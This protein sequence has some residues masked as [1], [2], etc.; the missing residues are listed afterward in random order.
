MKIDKAR[1]EYI[2][3]CIRGSN[4]TLDLLNL[5][6]SIIE[7]EQEKKIGMSRDCKLTDLWILVDKAI[8][9]M[10]DNDPNRSGAV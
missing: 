8:N 4:Y 9:E 2:K 7:D 5:L 3:E 6:K 10:S 1:H